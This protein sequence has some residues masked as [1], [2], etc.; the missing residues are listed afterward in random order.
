L[1]AFASLVCLY[2][3][4]RLSMAYVYVKPPM[5]DSKINTRI[6][7]L[8]AFAP[9]LYLMNSLWVFSNQ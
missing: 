2:V 7:K 3:V 9:I 8:L 4:E 6:L 1:I 5:Y